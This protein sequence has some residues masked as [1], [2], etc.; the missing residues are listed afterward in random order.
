M[1]LRVRVLACA[2][3]MLGS[4]AA[5]GL[6]SA[7]PRQNNGLTIAATPNPVIAGEG[8][9]IYGRLLG[10]DNGGQTIRLYHHVVGSSRGYTLVAT[11]TTSMNPSGYYEF[12]RAEGL[13]YTNRNWFVRGPS[14]THSRT[15]HERVIPLVTITASTT[16]SDTSH[17]VVFIGHVT[18]NH[19]FERVFLQQQ[20]GS[21]DDWRTLR[22]TFLG[23][24]S[25]YAFAY[26]WRRPG[27]HDVRVVF[28]G[29]DRN[30]RG[31]SDAVTVNIEQAQVPGFTINSSNPIVPYNGMVTISG[32]LN[33]S[34]TSNP[35]MV[36]LWGRTPDHRFTVLADGVTA[37][38][39]S[40]SFTQAGLTKNTIYYVATMPL[41]HT[42][43]RHTAVL[44]QGVRDMVTMRSS[45]S[46]ANTDQPVTFTGTVLPDKA[47]RVIYL[48]MQKQGEDNDWRT[49]E[50]AVVHHDS[51]FRFVWT[52][53]SPGTYTFRARIISDEDNLGSASPPVSITATAPAASTLPPAS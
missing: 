49:V 42:P 41:P 9:L 53:A 29:D 46:S 22:S 51:T 52:T 26:R 34:G 48:Q 21:S 44:Y 10:A 24:G 32:K 3:A 43:R 15:V 2:L 30:T 17:R 25:D 23:P 7:A 16:S 18:P 27:V 40:Y 47:G 39:G 35:A 4:L 45:S 13:V 12:T 6:A 37:S 50:V 36:Q 8:V 31:V 38:D 33:Q 19:G 1:R 11:T 14:G 20:I 28:R 5:A